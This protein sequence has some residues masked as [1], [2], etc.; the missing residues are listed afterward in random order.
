MAGGQAAGAWVRRRLVGHH[1]LEGAQARPEQGVEVVE[2]QAGLDVLLVEPA[3]GLVPRDVGDGVGLEVRRPVVVVADLAD[4]AVFA[5]GDL[6]HGHQ[7]LVERGDGVAAEEKRALHLAEGPE[8]LRRV[9]QLDLRPAGVHGEGGHGL[10]VT[11]LL[12]A[13]DRGLGQDLEGTALGLIED[14]CLGVEDA[15]RADP[16]AV[17]RHQGRPCVELDARV[18][19]DQ[20][21][22]GEPGVAGGV[23]H[24][25]DVVAEDGVAAEGDLPR[26]PGCVEADPGLP[27]LPIGVDQ[28]Q[29]RHRGAAQLG[30]ELDDLVVGGLGGGVEDAERG[31]LRQPLVL[32]TRQRCAGHVGVARVGR[33]SSPGGRGSR[34]R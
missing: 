5:A 31:E 33:R 10:E 20:G 1:R 22:V 19:D 24:H 15:Q 9:G 3:R 4:E 12:H 30:G 7:D 11:V 32:V 23:G 13:G 8:Q 14:A 16:M 18:T 2:L 27:P 29:R 25:E 17:L 21:V 28:A 26:C 34:G 6:Q